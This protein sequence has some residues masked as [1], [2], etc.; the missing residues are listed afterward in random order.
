ML[1]YLYLRK[2]LNAGLLLVVSPKYGI[3]TFTKTK[4]LNTSSA[5]VNNKINL[6][7]W[8]IDHLVVVGH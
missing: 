6:Y 3:S 4:D 5:T 8:H 2:V 1:T 7:L